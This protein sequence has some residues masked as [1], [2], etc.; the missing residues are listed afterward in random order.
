M[1]YELEK[2]F[3]RNPENCY[4]SSQWCWRWCFNAIIISIFL[5]SVLVP[6]NGCAQTVILNNGHY[7]VF[8]SYDLNVPVYVEWK[9]YKND[10][11]GSV[12]RKNMRF[13]TDRRL[14]VPRITSSDYTNSGF[15]RGHMC[16]A[17]DWAGNER[18][19][20]ETFLMSNIAPQ[21]QH[22][23]CGLWK[24]DEIYERI[25]AVQ[26]DSILVQCGPIFDGD[27]VKRFG[28]R[29]IAIPDRFWKRISVLVNDSIVIFHLYKND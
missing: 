14:N 9:L 12:K 13:K 4:S 28:K 16:P 25:L 6:I 19:M 23:N 18:K 2:N 29:N 1:Y 7:K 11:T 20:K 26:Y 8:W 3:N 5:M 10:C 22:L 17:A 21:T 27:T 15:Q 24:T